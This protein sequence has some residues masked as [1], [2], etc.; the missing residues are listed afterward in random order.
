MGEEKR[1]WH[2]AKVLSQTQSRDDAFIHHALYPFSFQ[3][4][5]MLYPFKRM[6]SHVFVLDFGQ[7]VLTCQPVRIFHCKLFDIK[8][9][10]YYLSL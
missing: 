8:V 4:T 2:A 3:S 9:C 1:V 5:P 10:W 7:N 6:F